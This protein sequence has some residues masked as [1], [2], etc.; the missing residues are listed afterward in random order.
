ME[1]TLG[2]PKDN[3]IL[4]WEGTTQKMLAA[5]SGQCVQEWDGVCNANAPTLEIANS[6]WFDDGDTLH[7]D[8]EAV[9]GNYTKQ[10]DFQS[11]DSSTAVNE[12]VKDSTNGLITDIVEE[13]KALFPPYV[14]LAINSIYLKARWTNQFQERHTNLDSFYS[15]A[16]RTTQVSEAHFMNMVDKYQYSHDAIENYQIIQ[17]KFAAS[18]SMSMIFVLPID[19]TD[20]DVEAVESSDLIRVLKEL[21]LTRVAL[22][23]PKFKFESE[24]EDSLK[25]ALTNTGI[26]ASFEEGSGSLCGLFQNITNC[27]RIFLDTII[28]KTVIDVNEKGVEAAAVTG[29]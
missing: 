28:Q 6:V 11:V 8:Y 26:K 2:F 13:G 5:S 3:L 19:D 27:E 24:Y 21:E 23:V 12:W 7:A 29:E 9:V 10:V 4:A 15:N 18:D 20:G 16:A 1:K 25:S 22:S 17:L 14:L